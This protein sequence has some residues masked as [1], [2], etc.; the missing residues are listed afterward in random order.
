MQG[1]TLL[2]MIT[3]C[4][5]NSRPNQDSYTSMNNSW[6]TKFTGHELTALHRVLSQ[7]GGK[8]YYYYYYY[9]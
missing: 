7:A 8:N 2:S 5:A 9:Y 6:K 3:K 4:D 1:Q